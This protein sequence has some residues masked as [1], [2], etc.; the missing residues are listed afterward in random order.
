MLY[1][2]TMNKPKGDISR[3]AGTVSIS[4]EEYE[5]LLYIK[6]ENE[7][8]KHELD[9]LKR[10]IFGQKSERF[11]PETPGQLRL[12]FDLDIEKQEEKKQ[13]TEAISYTRKKGEKTEIKGHSRMPLPEH[14]PRV[15]HVVGPKN[16]PE[17]SK[18]IG[19]EI[20]E[21]L[22]YAP[23]KLFVNKYIRP[24]YALPKEQGIVIGTLPTQPIH[25]GNAGPGLLSHLIISKYVDHLPF[26]RQAQMF[27]RQGVELA[28]STINGW[29][30]SGCRLAGPLYEKLKEKIFQGGYLMV[31][32]TPIPVLTKDKPGATHK[33]YLWVYYSP[34]ERMVLFDYR[35]GRGR[36]GP[37]GLLK[38]FKGLLQ[39]DGYGA[40]SMFENKEGIS[41]LGCMAHARRKF[42]EAMPNDKA[43][44]S[45]MLGLM[46]KLYDIERLS[47][48]QGLSFDERKALRQKESVPI[49]EE[50]ETWLKAQ[51]PQVLPKSAIGGAIAYMLKLWPRL[52]RYVDDGRC[53]IDNNLVENAIRPVALGR[54]NYL[55]AGSHEGAERAAMMYSLLGTCK[56]NNIEP[57]QWLKDTLARLPDCK[58]SQLAELLPLKPA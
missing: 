34:V 12:D 56:Q 35:K 18:K 9:K 36:D 58:Q 20:T 57:F 6:S 50:M 49:L 16:I 2:Y 37:G 4:R 55:F 8:L 7:Y 19:E 39:T 15:E 40:Y 13:A 17:G 52:V 45:H 46:Q 21:V 48:D 1:L 3:K 33:G 31:D 41:L 11:I 23:G 42:D 32:E 43:R 51:L 26:Y 28:E 27:K 24:K 22:E 25:R 44:A 5:S 53:E 47:R 38:D 10:M 54:K 29:F 14:L 30:G